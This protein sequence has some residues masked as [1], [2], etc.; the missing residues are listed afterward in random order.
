MIWYLQHSTNTRATRIVYSKTLTLQKSWQKYIK[1]K[2]D[3]L[4]LKKTTRRNENKQKVLQYLDICILDEAEVQLDREQLHGRNVHVQL[5]FQQIA[6]SPQP[7]VVARLLRVKI[8]LILLRLRV[9][10]FR[11]PLRAYRNR[12]K[13][14]R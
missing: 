14:M 12:Y 11:A 4:T 10:G 9:L 5:L 1:K 2:C 7:L 6:A 8:L 13:I 3:T